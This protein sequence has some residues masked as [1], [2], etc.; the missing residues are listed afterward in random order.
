M[1]SF[2]LR[3]KKQKYY[4]SVKSS[5]RR[6]W[7]DLFYYTCGWDGVEIVYTLHKAAVFIGPNVLSKRKHIP[8]CACYKCFYEERTFVQIMCVSYSLI[9]HSVNCYFNVERNK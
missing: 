8:A 2:L 1:C 5:G 7:E 3:Q 6:R 4:T 9:K